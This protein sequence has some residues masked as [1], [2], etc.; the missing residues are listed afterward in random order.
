MVNASWSDRY[1][2]MVLM[3]RFEEA[4]L[5]G[6]ASKAVHGELHTAIGQEAIAVALSEHI[7]A[8]DSLTST[9]RS[10]LHAIAKGIPLR[11]LLAEIFEK[12]TGMCGGFGG[13][14]HLFD[15][16]RRFSTTGIVGAS[17]PVALG[18]AYASKLRG[19]DAVAF[20]VV[21]DGSVNSGGFHE[22]MN[23]ASVLGL[24]L[25]VIIENN[26][27]AISVP[28]SAASA[29]A[30]LAERAVAYAVPG[31]RVDGLDVQ[32][33]SDAIGRAVAHARTD[34]PAI[35]EAM[36]YRFRGHYEGD[37][38]LYRD[39]GEKSLRTET[40]DPLVLARAFLSDGILDPV[41][42]DELEQSASAEIDELLASVLLDE[43]PDPASARDHVFTSGLAPFEGIPS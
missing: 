1:R 13:H 40:K 11:P 17:L 23:M 20:A 14:M 35:V 34:G 31:E 28:F 3:R 42:L 37:L 36:C 25:V 29:T 5:T 6:V 43:Q 26:E 21:G 32:A 19:S 27:W 9:H 38:D 33:T 30:T 24:G 15:R 18:H 41:L 39:Q 10:H 2:L 22:T 7:R 12:K 16:E 8:D 4:C